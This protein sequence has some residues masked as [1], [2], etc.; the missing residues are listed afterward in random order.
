MDDPKLLA[1]RLED[2]ANLASH[3]KDKFEEAAI[4]AAAKSIWREFH[5]PEQEFNTYI[6]EKVHAACWH[7]CA[8]VGYDV[9]NGH[10]RTFHVS[11]A[12]GQVSAL[13]NQLERRV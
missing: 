8:A 10:D 2:L 12:L 6:L 1:K 13:H 11:A 4:Y 9:T 3:A 5:E 7:I